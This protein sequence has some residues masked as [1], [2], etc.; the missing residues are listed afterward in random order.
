MLNYLKKFSRSYKEYAVH[1]CAIFSSYHW[2]NHADTIIYFI[3]YLQG[4][5]DQGIIINPKKYPQLEV[6]IDADSIGNYIK[7]TVP[8]DTRTVKY[9]SG[10][11]IM[12][13]ACPIIWT[14]KLQI[15]IA[16]R[17]CESEY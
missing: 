7:S 16:L 15:Y 17:S 5:L 8:F 3:K 4:I 9:C 1:Q 6:Y 13:C 12:F 14:S 11:I 2:H 10:F